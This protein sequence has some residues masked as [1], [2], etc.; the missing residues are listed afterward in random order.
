MGFYSF[1]QLGENQKT[2][3]LVQETCEMLGNWH[4]PHLEPNVLATSSVISKQNL[5]RCI[6]IFHTNFVGFPGV[7]FNPQLLS[8]IV[9]II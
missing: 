5:S 1:G 3:P 9:A 8:E 7:P 2:G 4:K 6:K